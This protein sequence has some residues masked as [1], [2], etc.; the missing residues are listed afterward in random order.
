MVGVVVVGYQPSQAPPLISIATI[1]RPMRTANSLLLVLR[2]D[3]LV[4]LHVDSTVLADSLTHLALGEGFGGV[5]VD[6]TVLTAVTV[7]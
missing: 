1:H 4:L 3:H 5:V 6:V 7:E 2:L